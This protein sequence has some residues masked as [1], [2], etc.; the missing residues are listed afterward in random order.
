MFLIMDLML[1]KKIEVSGVYNSSLLQIFIPPR[2][3]TVLDNFL[4]LLS[5]QII[6]L[7]LDGE[8]FMRLQ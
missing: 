6:Q 8:R 1:E 5:K 4:R 2:T 7:I 3:R